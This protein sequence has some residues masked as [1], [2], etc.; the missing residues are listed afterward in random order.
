MSLTDLLF[1][2][3]M[4]VIYLLAP[5]FL[6]VPPFVMSK[7]WRLDAPDL[8]RDKGCDETRECEGWE[9]QRVQMLAYSWITYLAVVLLL[10]ARGP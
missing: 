8:F 6:V 2:S 7:D 9:K 10:I 3:P 1:Q 5:F 4:P